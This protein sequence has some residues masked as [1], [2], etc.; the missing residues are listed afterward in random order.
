MAR[1]SETA[2]RV[3]LKKLSELSDDGSGEISVSLI[4]QCMSA[5]GLD[6]SRAELLEQLASTDTDGDGKFEVHEFDEFFARQRLV[7]N[8]GIAGALEPWD[9]GRCLP[10]DALPLA[11]KA[12]V[13]HEAVETAI[14]GSAYP[15]EALSHPPKPRCRTAAPSTSPPPSPSRRLLQNSATMTIA[16]QRSQPKER[17]YCFKV[18]EATKHDF[19]EYRERRK[20]Y[21]ETWDTSRR[22]FRSVHRKQLKTASSA[23]SVA[24]LNARRL[25]GERRW[26]PMPTIR[27]GHGRTPLPD[28]VRV[29][30]NPLLGV[31]PK[32]RTGIYAASSW[33]DILDDERPRSAFRPSMCPTTSSSGMHVL[34]LGSKTSSS[35]LHA[36]GL[37]VGKAARSTS[38]AYS[39]A[40]AAPTRPVTRIASPTPAPPSTSSTN[41]YARAATPMRPSRIFEPTY[42]STHAAA[43]LDEARRAA[44]DVVGLLAPHVDVEQPQSLLEAVRAAADEDNT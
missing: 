1:A 42:T 2:L 7:M 22:P 32:P 16:L 6:F 3:C 35:G 12:F 39:H 33:N 20:L 44:V 5:V 34:S 17:S 14:R 18:W 28:L 31:A 24:L 26:E 36:S 37:L 11:A 29:P 23:P 8:A 43:K 9:L 15:V 30:S 25:S 40:R 19:G 27:V 4:E 38:P 21:E 41:G 13:A 10:M